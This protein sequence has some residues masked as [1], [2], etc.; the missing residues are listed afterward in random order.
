MLSTLCAP[1]H[2]QHDFCLLYVDD[3]RIHTKGNDT[4]RTNVGRGASSF[5]PMCVSVCVRLQVKAALSAVE[6]K[7][8]SGVLK[9]RRNEPVELERELRALFVPHG[10][11]KGGAQ[12]VAPHTTRV[13]LCCWHC[14]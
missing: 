8:F 1:T 7:T 6:Y 13:V 10:R 5:K 11:P 14:V 3:S 12:Q 2:P 4:L 9:R